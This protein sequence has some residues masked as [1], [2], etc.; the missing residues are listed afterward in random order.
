MLLNIIIFYNSAFVG[1]SS[2]AVNGKNEDS[3]GTEDG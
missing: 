3:D 1:T 2:F